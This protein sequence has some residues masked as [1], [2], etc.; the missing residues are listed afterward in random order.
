MSTETF[1]AVV[2]NG[3]VVNMVVVEAN[4]SVLAKNPSW[5]FID[6]NPQKVAIGWSYDG[7]NFI[8]PPP[9]PPVD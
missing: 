7:V 9:L 8:P 2:D 4:A 3:K 6:T 5:I 1:A